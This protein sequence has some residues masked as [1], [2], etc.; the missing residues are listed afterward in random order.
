MANGTAEFG[1]KAK[2]IYKKYPSLVVYDIL[3]IVGKALYE[4][5]ID[6]NWGFK[7]SED[8]GVIFF[9]IK[10]PTGPKLLSE[11]LLIAA[12]FKVMKIRVEEYFNNGTEITQINLKTDFKISVPQKHIFFEA[13]L[14][15]GIEILSFD[16]IETC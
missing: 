15:C 10:S 3:N 14:K 5:K 8:D 6:P 11:Q 2:E 7:L 12:F 16:S 9:E 1:E 13:G 4:I